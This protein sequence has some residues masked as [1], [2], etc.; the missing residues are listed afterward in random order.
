MSKVK[1]W[2][3]SL[4]VGKNPCIKCQEKGRDN[5]GDNFHY[6]GEGNGGFCHSCEYTIPSEEFIK[7]NGGGRSSQSKVKNMYS[8]KAEKPTTSRDVKVNSEFTLKDWKNLIKELTYNPQGYR[9]L[10]EEVCKRYSVLHEYSTTTGEIVKQIYPQTKDYKMVGYSERHEPK[11]FRKIGTSG[12]AVDLFGQHLY[13]N[14]TSKDIVITGGELDALSASL[15]FSIKQRKGYEPIPAVSPT[16]G[17]TSAYKQL[18]YH[19]EWL[20]GFDRIILAFDNDDA[21]RAATDK[22]VKV[23][24]KGKAYILKMERKDPNEYLVND[25]IERFWNAYWR[26]EKY[27]P[28]GITAST[29]LEDAMIEYVSTPR[30][31]LP[32]FMRQ[33]QAMLVGGLPIGYIVNLLAASG[34][35]KS[36]IVNAIIIH[37]AMKFPEPIGVVSLEASEGEYGVNLAS[38]YCKRN[39]N[40]IEGVE[41]KREYLELP[42]NRKKREELWKDDDGDPNFY[43]VDADIENMQDKCEYLV[44]GLGCRI[45][46]FDPLQDIL[47]ELSGED[48]AKWMK[49]EKDMVKK[50]KIIIIN[51][52][53]SRKSGSGA[54]ANSRGAELN[55]EDMMG[56]SS[57]FKS[58]GINIV[59][60]RDK[61]AEDDIERNTTTARITKARGTGK[62]GFAGE[63]LYI[64]EEDQMYD[65]KWYL[66][67]HPDY[68]KRKK[69]EEKLAKGKPKGYN[70][71]SRIPPK[72]EQS[73][74]EDN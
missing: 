22:A 72:G 69:I 9:G 41:A 15:M 24:P 40:L 45:I 64:P 13:R 49:W 21:G 36:T 47:D 43:I 39:I 27:V 28:N 11:D 61:E 20:D 63:W 50:E 2:E 34:V 37:L 33:L 53:H 65:K 19:Y 59:L 73:N 62:T 5:S 6:Y 51:I 29:S 3:S 60:G 57:I 35:G 38:S 48:Q 55:E 52:S 44:R 46:V 32:P 71:V 18:Q 58:G 74:E 1:E 25:D 66:D 26:V 8:K 10:T 14:S 23:L 17:E 68:G 31:S 67:K 70:K 30:V 7:E 42:E 54:K 16:N 56:H 12:N 4:E